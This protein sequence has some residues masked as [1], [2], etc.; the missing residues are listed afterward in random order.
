MAIVERTVSK[1]SLPPV[2][3]TESFASARLTTLTGRE[4]RSCPPRSFTR[5]SSA[6]TTLPN[7]PFM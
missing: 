6:S 7:D 3:S 4:V 5:A 2:N 1:V